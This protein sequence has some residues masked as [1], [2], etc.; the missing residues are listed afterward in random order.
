MVSVAFIRDLYHGRRMAEVM[1]F[2]MTVFIMVP[3]IAPAMGSGILLLG[4]WHVCSR[5]SRG[6]RSD[7]Q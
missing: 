6:S 4:D 2:V 3:A 1:S 5:P 7:S